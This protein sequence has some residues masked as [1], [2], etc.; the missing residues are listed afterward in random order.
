MPKPR[1]ILGEKNLTGSK[2]KNMRIQKHLSQ[3][4]LAKKLQLIG[5]DIDKNVITR[6]ETNKRYI[7]DLELKAFA[8]IFQVSYEY[9]IDGKKDK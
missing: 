2:I 6:M 9:L 5:V 1:G 8:E 3:Q 4:T 7:T